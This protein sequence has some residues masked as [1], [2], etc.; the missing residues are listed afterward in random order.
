MHAAREEDLALVDVADPGCDLLV[1]QGARDLRG[2]VETLQ[3]A[4]HCVEVG[5]GVAEVR[6]ETVEAGGGSPGVVLRQYFDDRARK[7]T[8]TVPSSTS[9]TT[10]AR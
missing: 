5:R 10:R 9:S 1:E 8:A 7:Q 2:R 6:A 3:P 4:Q